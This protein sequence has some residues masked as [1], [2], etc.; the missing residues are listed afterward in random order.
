M[1]TAACFYL[2]SNLCE[3]HL[4][5][6]D[7]CRTQWWKQNTPDSHLQV[8]WGRDPVIAGHYR[9]IQTISVWHLLLISAMQR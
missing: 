4:N 8:P 6:W 1:L 7:V 9:N 3:F 2:N 5:R